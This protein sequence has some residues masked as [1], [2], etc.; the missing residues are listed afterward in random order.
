MKKNLNTVKGCLYQNGSYWACKFRV[1][2]ETTNKYK[3]ITRSTGIR[4]DNSSQRKSI[5]A[6]NKARKIM[7]ELVSKY[8]DTTCYGDMLLSD[9][10]GV[11]LKE[12]SADI[13][14]TTTYQYQK[15]YEK[16]IK[17]YWDKQK[18]TLRD[19]DVDDLNTFY[20]TKEKEGL[21]PNTVTKF[22]TM[23]HSVL[24]YACDHRYIKYNVATCAKLPKKK[25]VKHSYYT[26]DEMR[27]LLEVA[28]GTVLELPVVLACVLGL[29]RSEIV[30]LRW[31]AIDFKRREI[32]VIGKVVNY[33]EKDSADRYQYS[34]TMKT[35]ASESDF[36]MTDVMYNYLR[37][38]YNKQKKI[39]SV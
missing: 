2:D 29:R 3:Q 31:S 15:M 14:M 38:L 7:E 8:N 12:R 39:W 27:Q 21:S 25:K 13:Q 5:L 26:A 19:L 16:H 6:E 34:T 23:L 30:G 10:V 35:D 32:H 36:P 22:H 18:I 11:W 4:I 17:P 1:W 9:F 20:R 24:R 37:D 28:Q 33:H